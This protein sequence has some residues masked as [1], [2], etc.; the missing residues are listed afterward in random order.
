MKNKLL[1]LLVI[2]LFGGGVSTHAN[3]SRLPEAPIY[4]DGQSITTKYIM[5]DGHLLVPALFIKH[6][7]AYVDWDPEYRSVVFRNGSTLFALPVGKKHSDDYIGGIWRRYPLPVDT[8]E[9]LGEPFVPLIDVTRKLGMTARY[10]TILNRTYISSN[11]TVKRN[12]INRTNTSEKLVAL[13]FDD[14]PDDYYTPRMLDVLKEKGVPATFFVVGR[15]VDA[16]PQIMK[17]I[18]EEGHGIAN[19]TQTHPNLRTQWSSNVRAQ[20]NTTQETMARV[21]GR[22]P[23]IFRPPYGSLTKA[24]VVVLNELGMKN[25]MWSVDTVDWSGASA[26]EILRTVHRDITPGGIILQHN[27][28]SNSRL[29]DGS[30][31]ALPRIIDEL[32]ARGYKFVTIQTLLSQ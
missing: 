4:I 14:G 29:L 24:D 22:R 17:R 31:E 13:T 12:H 11:M 32:T 10:D 1:I 7:G 15:Q 18:V 19:H 6:T 8:V 25:I 28:Q 26:D 3:E 9:F 20:V 21:V 27:F 16:F 2:L 5:R 23:D 30:L